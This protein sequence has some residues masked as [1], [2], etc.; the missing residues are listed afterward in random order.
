MSN[1][2]LLKTTHSVITAAGIGGVADAQVMVTN[3]GTH[4]ARQWARVSARQAYETIRM[5]LHIGPDVTEERREQIERFCRTCAEAIE[6]FFRSPDPLKAQQALE[7]L[8]QVT[9]GSEWELNFGHPD[10]QGHLRLQL[11]TNLRQAQ[12]QGV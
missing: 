6:P 1:N 11:E 9:K 5:L 8:L 3:N 2:N 12:Q 4:S 10:V 7:A